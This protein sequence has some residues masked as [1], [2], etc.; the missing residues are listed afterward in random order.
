MLLKLDNKKRKYYAKPEK[1]IGKYKIATPEE[2]VDVLI[3]ENKSIA[4]F[5]D[6]EFDFIYGIGMN[7]QKYDPKLAERLIEVLNSHEKD[8]IIRNTKCSK[9]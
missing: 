1:V 8:L 5:G 7:Y 4:R 3:N 2:T 6:G 9:S